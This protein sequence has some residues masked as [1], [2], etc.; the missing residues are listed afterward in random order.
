MALAQNVNNMHAYRE[1]LAIDFGLK[2]SAKTDNC[3][4]I[5]AT[6]IAHNATMCSCSKALS[7]VLIIVVV[8]VVVVVVVL[9]VVVAIA[10]YLHMPQ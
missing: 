7:L 2:T 5:I 4:A 9:V 6:I 10:V 3:L 1:L 8:L